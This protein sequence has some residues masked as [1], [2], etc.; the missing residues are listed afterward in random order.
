MTKLKFCVLRNQVLELRYNHRLL[1]FFVDLNLVARL[2]LENSSNQKLEK[3][4]NLS[5]VTPDR[6]SQGTHTWGLGRFCTPLSSVALRLLERSL[7]PRCCYYR[8][9]SLIV[10]SGILYKIII[11]IIWFSCPFGVQPDNKTSISVKRHS[12]KINFSRIILNHVRG[13]YYSLSP[14]NQRWFCFQ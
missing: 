8:K 4:T 3:K 7:S 12:V 1:E 9:V 11:I 13:F 6:Q 14:T 5:M 10:A 2:S